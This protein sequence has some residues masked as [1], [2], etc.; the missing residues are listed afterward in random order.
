MKKRLSLIFGA[1]MIASA[2]SAAAQAATIAAWD[3]S[4]LTGGAGSFGPSPYAST[5]TLANTTNSGLVRGSGIGTAS[6]SGAAAAWGGNDFIIAS[7]T[8]ATAV[9]GNEFAT[10][11][12]QASPGY[13]LSLTSIDPYNIRRSASG[14]STGQWQY[15]LDGTT[16][17]DIGS[18]ITWGGTTSNLGNAQTLIDLSGIGALQSVP[19]STTVT[20]RVVTWGATSTGGTWYFNSPPASA[21]AIDLSITGE[22][23]AVPEPATLGLA[24]LA[25]AAAFA[26]RRRS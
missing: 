24:S 11:A 4:T 12:I 20:L 14:P 21:A 13:L 1:A 3:F 19:A 16:F 2:L 23:V 9:A 17:T 10:I 15:S 6:G 5:S 25:V 22:V 18:S 26:A 8:F 7:P